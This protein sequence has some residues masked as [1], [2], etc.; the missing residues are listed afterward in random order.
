MCVELK[1][2]RLE[3]VP[4]KEGPVC[5]LNMRCE[6]SK[7]GCLKMLT[8]FHTMECKAKCVWYSQHK[9]WWCDKWGC[10]KRTVYRRK[11]APQHEHWGWRKRLFT[12]GNSPEPSVKK[13]N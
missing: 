3:S 6:T 12:V 8:S 4:F 5:K 7:H 1:G 11:K 10:A 9:E 13:E 2:V